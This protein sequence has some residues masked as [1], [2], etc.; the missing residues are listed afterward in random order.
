MIAQIE[1]SGSVNQVYALVKPVVEDVIRQ[2]ENG[3]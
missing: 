1:C 3:Y 2:M